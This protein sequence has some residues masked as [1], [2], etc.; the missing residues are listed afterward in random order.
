MMRSGKMGIL[1]ATAIL[2]LGTSGCSRVRGH[3]GFISDPA[4]VTAITPG[5]DNRDSVQKTLGRP[6]F[7]SQFG[8]QDWYYVGRDTKTLAFAVPKATAQTA[9]RVRF[10]A[11]GNVSA[12][13]QLGMQH[14]ASINPSGAKTP[15]LGKS[16]SFWDDLF[17][18]IGTVGSTTPAGG[19]A[20]NPN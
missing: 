3:Q 17:G 12:V 2:A 14:I 15:T 1:V 10:D 13:D 11:K 6:S 4:L 20:D 9:M 19:T 16:R 8:E 5:V 7:I 18:N